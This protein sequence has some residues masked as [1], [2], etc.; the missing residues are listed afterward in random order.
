MRL[1]SAWQNVPLKCVFDGLVPAL[2]LCV[3]DKGFH[4]EILCLGSWS[5]VWAGVEGAAALSSWQDWS[6]DN[7]TSHQH[8]ALQ[9][10]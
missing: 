7:W 1:A 2:W 6:S 5:K 4:V 10:Q 8:L 3:T 9:K